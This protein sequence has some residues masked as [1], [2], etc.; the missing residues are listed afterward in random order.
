MVNL[1]INMKNA[2]LWDCRKLQTIED[3]RRVEKSITLLPK[4][5]SKDILYLISVFDSNITFS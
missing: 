1:H 3:N 2:R 5:R 4:T